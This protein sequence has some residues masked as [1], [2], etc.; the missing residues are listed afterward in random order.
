MGIIG[1]S[2]F[3]GTKGILGGPGLPGLSGVQGVPG[4]NGMPGINGRDAI[5][6]P[7]GDPGLD[8]M[9]GLN[10]E[11]GVAGRTGLPG[12]YGQK[13]LPGAYRC[14]FGEMNRNQVSRELYC[15]IYGRRIFYTQVF[16]VFI[17]VLLLLLYR[18]KWREWFFWTTRPHTTTTYV[19]NG[20]LP[21]HYSN[22]F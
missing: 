20:L 11:K 7:P 4:P 19:E 1:R 14:S 5:D 16:L 22:I 18:P 17:Y 2:G 6:G 15:Y 8:G 12:V 9:P 21:N 13:G 10:G 3:S